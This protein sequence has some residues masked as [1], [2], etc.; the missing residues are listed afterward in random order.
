MKDDIPFRPTLNIDPGM[1]RR[2]IEN[3][4]QEILQQKASGCCN[5]IAIHGD[6]CFRCSTCGNP[7]IT[8]TGAV[9]PG[10]ED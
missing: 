7:L 4:P 6:G 9:H 3:T 8:I 1:A 2:Q 5:A 10:V